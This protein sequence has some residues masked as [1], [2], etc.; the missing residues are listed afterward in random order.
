MRI[1]EETMSVVC[2][3]QELITVIKGFTDK[4]WCLYST[5]VNT[6]DTGKEQIVQDYCLVFTTKPK[7]E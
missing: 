7:E 2:N 4:G 5:S 3:P 1:I 6:I